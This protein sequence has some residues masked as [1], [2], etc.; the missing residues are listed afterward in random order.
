VC[1]DTGTTSP[2]TL[3]GDPAESWA[4]A[5]PSE[6]LKT[7]KTVAIHGR[8]GYVLIFASPSEDSLDA[9]S[10]AFAALLETFRFAA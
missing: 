4:V 1:S 5:C 3:G 2:T 7:I 6:G 10:S 8:K 9:D